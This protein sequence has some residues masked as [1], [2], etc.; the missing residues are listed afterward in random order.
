[1]LK[2]M[3]LFSS[4][5]LL[6][7]LASVAQSKPSFKVDYEHD[8]FLKDGKPF[9]YVS[10]SIHYFR[11]PHQA[12]KDR[13]QKLRASGANAVQTYIEWSS[14]E[15]EPGKY[16][17]EG[18]N[19]VV[20]FIKEAQA[21]DLLVILRPGPYICAERDYGGFPYWLKRLNPKMKLRTNDSSFMKAVDSWFSVL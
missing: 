5:I 8:T 16:S 19:D 12:W 7:L 20:A 21:L 18:D 17:F 3:E 1:M 10:G 14:H 11:V 6:T 2:A 9:R 13:L 4:A 15:P